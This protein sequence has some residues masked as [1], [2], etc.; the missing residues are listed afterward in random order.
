MMHAK[1]KKTFEHFLMLSCYKVIVKQILFFCNRV[2]LVFNYS[3]ECFVYL[4]KESINPVK[5]IQNRKTRI[6]SFDKRY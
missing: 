4:H 6:D 2:Y 3:T 5:L 1:D